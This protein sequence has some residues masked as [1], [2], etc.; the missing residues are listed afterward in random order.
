M[1]NKKMNHI[2]TGTVIED[3]SL[4]LTDL[5]QMTG[6]N[7]EWI[8]NM[9]QESIIEPNQPYSEESRTWLFS[10]DCL[11]RV[12]TSIRLEKD[13]GINPAGVALVLELLNELDKLRTQ[14]KQRN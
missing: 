5:C 8:F 4:S 12:R 10:G 7:V 6:C 3:E 14:L 9:V 1:P 11:P 13:L 2:H